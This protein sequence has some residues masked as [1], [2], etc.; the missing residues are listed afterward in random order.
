M[1][2]EKFEDLICWQKAR[3]LTNVIYGLT[4]L[5]MFAKDFELVRQIR[6]AAVSSMSNIAE[7]FDRW[8]RKELIRFL[9]I[10]KGSDGEVRSQLYVALDQQYITA[11]QFSSAMAA[12]L[13][14]TKTIGGLIGYLEQRGQS[15]TARE[16]ASS[17]DSSLD[18]CADFCNLNHNLTTGAAS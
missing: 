5:P 3:T 2:I 1:K 16:T 12:T 4:R 7:G 18:L 13:E 6:G 10:A 17:D 14:T 8:S 15:Y 11:Q 9:D